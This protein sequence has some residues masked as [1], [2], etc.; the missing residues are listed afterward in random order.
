MIGLATGDGR[1]A[2]QSVT[3]DRRRTGRDRQGRSTLA[4]STAAAG[5]NALQLRSLQA[6]A[7]MSPAS[8][9][10]AAL[11]RLADGTAPLQAELEEEELL[12]GRFEP[13]V[14]REA[15]TTTTA[16]A[17]GLPAPLKSGLEQ[18]GGASLDDVRVHYGSSRPAQVGA[19]AYAQGTD[20]HLAPGQEHHLPH[21]GW[22]AVQQRQ[23]R[24]PVTG[25]V[26]GQPLNADP[27]LEREADV[28]G[29]RALEQAA[30][31]RRNRG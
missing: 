14:Q 5:P 17:S 6:M 4:K 11:Q 2:M 18:L 25:A 8:T 13:A 26:A 22:H 19:L 31:Q 21:E 29:T 7:T 16:A 15:D 20:I 27:G 28:M 10:A 3:S 23:G 24:V 30:T 1:M 12:Q 9:A